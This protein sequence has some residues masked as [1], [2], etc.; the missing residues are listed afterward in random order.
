MNT[1]GGDAAMARAW[2]AL[3]AFALF[4]WDFVV[5]DDAWLAV[6]VV[7]C[8]AAVALLHHAGEPAWWVLPLGVTLLIAW[9]A[10][11]AARKR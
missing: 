7:V 1:P 6:G 5:G 4:W 9:S 8:V 3:R 11:R 2:R 10:G